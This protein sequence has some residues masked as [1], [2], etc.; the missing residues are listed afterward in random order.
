MLHRTSIKIHPEICIR[1]FWFFSQILGGVKF[2]TLKTISNVF[3]SVL[4]GYYKPH[5][6][7][8][9]K[10]FTFF[11]PFFVKLTEMHHSMPMSILVRH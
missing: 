10:N 4:Y 11:P 8:F 2:F 3:I 5:D 1:T 7:K 9:Q 6:L